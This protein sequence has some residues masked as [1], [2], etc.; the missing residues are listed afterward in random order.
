MDVPD[1]LE[2]NSS[3]Y[4]WSVRAFRLLRKLLQV[5]INLHHSEGQIGRGHIFLFNHFSRFETFIPQYLIYRETGAFCRSVAAS[6]FFA[7]DSTF[8]AYLRQVGVVPNSHP[9]LLPLLA[10]EILR[11]RKIIV[12]PEGGMI[13]DRRV[14]DSKGRYRIYSRTS[15][16]HRK[17]HTGATV[18]ASVLDL[19]KG[20]ILRLHEQGRK[21]RLEKWAGTLGLENQER[22]LDAARQ[23]TTIVPANITFYPLRVGDNILR[24]SAGLFSRR[25][26]RRLAEELVIEGNILLKDTDM[27]LRLGPA[28]ESAAYWSG[29]QTA[30]V[31]RLVGRLDSL[32]AFF[33]LSAESKGL[34]SR[35]LR[36]GVGHKARRIR[37]DCMRIMYSGVTINLSHLASKLILILME[38]KQGEVDRLFF[39]KTLY[40]AGRKLRGEAAVHCHPSLEDPESYGAVLDGRCAKLEQFL[41]A[42]VS[43]NLIVAEP[44]RYRFLPKL[45]EEYR[46]DQVRL[47]NP[48]VVYANE[49]APVREVDQAIEQ[50]LEEAAETGPGDLARMRF[51]DELIAYRR[52]KKKFHKPEHREINAQEQATES[53]AP[54]L[55]ATGEESD[56]GVVLVHGLLASPAE[57][58][59]FGDKLSALG[60]PVLGVRLAGHGTSPWDLRERDWEDWFNSVKRGYALM[61]CLAQRI[62]MVGF[63]TGGALAL[64][65][66]AE[67]PHALVG[68]AAVCSPLRFSDGRMVFVPALHGANTIVRRIPALDGVMPFRF[69]EPEHAHINYCNIPIRSLYELRQLVADLEERLPQVCCPL[70]LIQASDDPTVDPVSAELIYQRV[71]SHEKELVSVPSERHGILYQDVGQTQATIVD[72]LKRVSEHES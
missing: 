31:H 35:L 64:R 57:I 14:V 1:T 27:D 62:C 49:A 13:K 54:F 24:Q 30:I 38:R 59:P 63:S 39:A 12:F 70:S 66:A 40:L 21:D 61:S 48:V 18:L 47:E 68:V 5:N 26:S 72:F 15:G 19:F 32:E 42:A 51:D 8:S 2:I 36:W 16:E 71:G 53:G 25:I 65:L 9:Q 67:Q 45:G 69:R 44:G 4:E 23:P 7:E 10:S 34:S 56:L 22:L 55:L 60:Y 50:A 43:A 6:D 17:H 3:T 11:G 52:A 46:L 58:R 29:W 20:V 41:A 37:D 28:V 33:G